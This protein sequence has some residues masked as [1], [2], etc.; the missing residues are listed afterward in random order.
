MVRCGGGV[1]V[2]RSSAAGRQAVGELATHVAAKP[3]VEGLTKAPALAYA[4][5]GVRVHALA[6]EPILTDNLKRAGTEA[7]LAAARA[8]PLK[9]IGEPH[10][11]AVATV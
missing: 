4:R 3:G 11:V 5:Q 10:E 1:I 9:R 8:M 2:N 6:P 7:Q